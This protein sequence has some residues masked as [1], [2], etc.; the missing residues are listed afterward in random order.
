[1]NNN[2]FSY[3]LSFKTAN[4]KPYDLSKRICDNMKKKTKSKYQ[5]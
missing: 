4:E 3:V 5:N 1:M 2:D